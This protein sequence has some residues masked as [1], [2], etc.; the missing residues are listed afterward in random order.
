[1]NSN[2]QTQTQTDRHTQTDRQT[3]R[4]RVVV[5]G[6]GKVRSEFIVNLLIFS[7]VSFLLFLPLL[8]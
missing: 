2:T 1:M 7:F 6:V 5:V 3:D 8:N 4:Q